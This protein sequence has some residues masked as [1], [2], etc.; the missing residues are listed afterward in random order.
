MGAAALTIASMRTTVIFVKSGN[1]EES[2]QKGLGTEGVASPKG[3]KEGGKAESHNENGD[4]EQPLTIGGGGL[5][6]AASQRE[7][8]GIRHCGATV[9]G[10]LA[11]A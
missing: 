1:G 6:N 2:Q 3:G 11:V 8:N 7:D 5:Q 10:P 4:K 9:D